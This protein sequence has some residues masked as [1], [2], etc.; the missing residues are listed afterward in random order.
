MNINN[1]V[2]P[3]IQKMVAY[4]SA[5]HEFT[6]AATTF[7]DA[8]ENPFD[9]GFN[10]YPD[11]LQHAVKAKLSQI[12]GVPEENIFLG[13]GSDE[14]ID[15]L[16]R[17][18]C[19]PQVDH[20]LTLPPTYGMYKVSA[21]I[22]DIE[23]RMIPLTADFQ[24]KVDDI[25]NAANAFSKLLFI[26]SPNNPT[27]NDIE[28][29]RIEALIQG[30][31]GIVVVDEAYID[32][33]AQPS[34]TQFLKKHNNLVV[35]QTFSKA[36][37]LAGIRLGMAFASSAIIQL[38]NKVKPPYNVN[39]LTQEAALKAL[40][41]EAAQQSW[42]QTIKTQRTWLNQ[43]LGALGMVKKIHPTHANFILA[44]FENPKK[45]YQYLV[46]KGIIIRDRTTVLLCDDCL[47]IT[48][49]TEGENRFLIESLKEY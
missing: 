35:L 18:F 38:F 46:E 25:L 7:L 28:L 34:C 5:R 32:F 17:I 43:Q 16:M 8:N 37:G 10:R 29:E 27:G 19:R 15:L 30:F 45:V 20:I 41:N 36:W 6:G 14:A 12:K 49:G 26:C 24:P 23:N 13:N 47:R 22:S 42:V 31:K 39:Q 1:L 2:R 11:P 4:S 33:A 40:E 44:Q 21:A 3:N 48:V 9:T